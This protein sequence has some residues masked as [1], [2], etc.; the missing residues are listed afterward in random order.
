MS[1]RHGFKFKFKDY[2]INMRLSF[3][4]EQDFIKRITEDMIQRG[5]NLRELSTVML[6]IVYEK[7]PLKG[8]QDEQLICQVVE[9]A[10]RHVLGMPLGLNIKNTLIYF[11][12]H[13]GWNYYLQW[14]LFK[15]LC[16]IF[17][18]FSHAHHCLIKRNYHI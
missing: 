12:K 14:G 1:I 9:Q 7:I 11:S 18:Q 5:K 6:A 13:V 8:N 17:K 4:A 16:N 15:K 2:V 3:P 10:T